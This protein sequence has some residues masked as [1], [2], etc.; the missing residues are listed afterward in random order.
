[1]NEHKDI[2]IFDGEFLCAGQRHIGNEEAFDRGVGGVMDEHHCFF[3][4]AGFFCVIDEGLIV[5]E[6]Q[7]H[8]ADDDNVGI[9]LVGNP[10][11]QVSCKARR[12]WKRSGSFVI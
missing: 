4:R 11:E 7:P 9:G 12:Q 5:I 1:M 6:S 3:K 8:P 2:F 10:H